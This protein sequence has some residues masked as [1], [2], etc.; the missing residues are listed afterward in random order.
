MKDFAA[1]QFTAVASGGLGYESSTL[2]HAMAWHNGCLYLGA[3][4][5]RAASPADAGRILRYHPEEDRWDT[6]HN[7]P[8]RPTT[9][10]TLAR[11]EKRSAALGGTP[12]PNAV[13][14]EYGIRSL[15]VYQ[16]KRDP[17]PCLYAGTMSVFG[18]G[19]L[20]SED[21]VRFEPVVEAG[22][23]DD[24]IMSFRGLT[25]YNGRL[26]AAPA[27]TVS[28]EAADLNF[29]PEAMVYCSDDPAGGPDTWRPACPPA[30]GDDTNRS[31]FSIG[32][33]HGHLYAGTA[34]A[35][36]GFQLWRT[37]AKGTAPFTWE[38]VL[39]N[40]AWRFNHN[41]SVATLC[42]FGDDLYVGSGIPGLGKDTQN[43][44]GPAAAELIRVREEGSWELIF[45]EVRCTPD[46]LKVPLAAMGPGLDDPYN[47]VLWSMCVHDGALY[48]GTHQWEP[49]DYALNGGGAPLRGGYQLWR[50]ADGETWENL[51]EDALGRV[52]ATGLRSMQSTPAGLFIG[53]SVHTSLLQILSRKS[54]SITPGLM[55]DR[56]GFD[57]LLGRDI[58]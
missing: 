50:S 7:A 45:G 36:R 1:M 48:V 10:E 17:H 41:Y 12:Q 34:S 47:S 6:A 46:G 23:H 21:G 57:V 42:A 18:G 56:N 20:R 30:F 26:F 54:G 44:V 8:A 51:I 38:R 14:R 24:H 5:P 28:P 55:R 13:A 31:V 9:P 3:T 37:K 27:G 52:S 25:A 43:D 39:I 53:T 16:G 15:L 22:L 58:S 19:I 40:G 2:A 11:I 4:A 29:A 49:Y 35:T 32:V 33:A